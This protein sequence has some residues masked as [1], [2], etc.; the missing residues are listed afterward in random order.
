M[1]CSALL[2]GRF[3]VSQESRFQVSKRS[4]MF[5]ADLQVIRSDDF[6]N[7]VF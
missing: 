1:G 7:S 2:Y 6:P 3:D 5:R 4:N